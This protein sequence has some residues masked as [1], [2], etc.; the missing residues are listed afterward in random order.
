MKSS[1]IFVKFQ[2]VKGSPGSSL[3]ELRQIVW[4]GGGFVFVCFFIGDR[5]L[6]FH[7]PLLDCFTGLWGKPINW[8]IKQL[9]DY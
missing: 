6:K 1:M 5:I 8:V 2:S 9:N 4:K 3:R 7:L